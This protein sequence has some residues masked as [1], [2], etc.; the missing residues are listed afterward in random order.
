MFTHNSSVIDLTLK[1]SCFKG[2]KANTQIRN[3]NLFNALSHLSALPPWFVLV[4]ASGLCGWSCF[5][6]FL[7]LFFS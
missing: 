3:L 7:F 1:K 5:F 4:D 6:F 2:D